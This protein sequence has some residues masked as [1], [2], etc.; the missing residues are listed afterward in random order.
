MSKNK[1]KA[2]QPKI[3]KTNKRAIE[4][5]NGR[6]YQREMRVRNMF[7][8]RCDKMVDAQRTSGDRVYP[9]RPDLANKV[10]FVCPECGNYATSS[11]DVIPTA[12]IR[13]IRK[14]IHRVIDPLWE[15]GQVSRGWVYRKMKEKLGYEFH[16]GSL[17]SMAEGE[18]AL[19]AANEIVKE[20]HSNGLRAYLERKRTKRR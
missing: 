3:Y 12:Q 9:S 19:K 5:Y 20:V 6:Q 7:C 14:K 1:N 10:M 15:Q 16:N 8:M 18:R 11:S 17:R 4:W 13:N 2:N